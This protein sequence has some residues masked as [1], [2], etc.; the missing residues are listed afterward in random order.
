MFDLIRNRLAALHSDEEG[1]TVVEIVLLIAL[2]VL[3][4]VLVLIIFGQDIKDFI[5]NM[6]AN[7]KKEAT[8][9]QNGRFVS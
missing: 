9:L 3:P 4:I 7:T 2:I 6:W 1:L 5:K 8:A